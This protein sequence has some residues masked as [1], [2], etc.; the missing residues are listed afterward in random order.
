MIEFEVNSYIIAC[1]EQAELLHREPTAIHTPHLEVALKQIRKQIPEKES[2]LRPVLERIDQQGIDNFSIFESQLYPGVEIPFTRVSVSSAPAEAPKVTY[3]IIPG[4]SWP[5]DWHP[6]TG[7]EVVYDRVI[8]SL[9][10]SKSKNI[11]VYSMGSPNAFGG[12]VSQQWVESLK[13]GLSP[14]GQV[15]A[16]FVNQVIDQGEANRPDRIILNG[17]SLGSIIAELAARSPSLQGRKHLQLLLDSPVS[18]HNLKAI[19][20]PL[21]FTVE[22]VAR[23]G[24]DERKRTVQMANSQFL[25]Q[26]GEVL[27]QRGINTED[28]RQ[29]LGL[30]RQAALIDVWNMVKGSPLDTKN[31]RSFIRRGMADPVS[32]SPVMLLR[33]LFQKIQGKNAVTGQGRSLEF[34]VAATHT[35]ERYRIEKWGEMIDRI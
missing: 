10:Q 28:S 31:T 3:V 8:G 12:K 29:Q 24:F 35:I 22:A 6:F 19:Q 25:R 30:K 7:W 4:W 17:S 26:L 15:Y 5:P 14:Y 34:A 13:T 33:A 11:Q 9:L 16:E 27:K 32:F 2:A 21:G 23:L 1:M 18:S 20:I